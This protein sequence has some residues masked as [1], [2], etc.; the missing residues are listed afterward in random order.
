M[1]AVTTTGQIGVE[2]SKILIEMEHRQDLV[3]T[4][5]T[6]ANFLVVGLKCDDD[7]FAKVIFDKSDDRAE[8]YTDTQF[9]CYLRDFYPAYYL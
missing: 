9:N 2:I 4:E 5:V 6:S 7:I 8:I 3:F 1:I